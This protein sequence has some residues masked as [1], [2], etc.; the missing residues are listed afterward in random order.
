MVC[1][2]FHA[3]KTEPENSVDMNEQYQDMFEVDSMEVELS[4]SSRSV[5]AEPG[6]QVLHVEQ[7]PP[8]KTEPSKTGPSETASSQN[9]VAAVTGWYRNMVVD[10]ELDTTMEEDSPVEPTPAPPPPSKRGPKRGRRSA[11]FSCNLCPF[12][13]KKKAGMA[14]HLKKHKRAASLRQAAPSQTKER[15]E[16]ENDSTDG[17]MASKDVDASPSATATPEKTL[18]K[19]NG[20]H[21]S[22][23]ATPKKTLQK[24]NGQRPSAAATPE[25][26]LGKSNSQ[27]AAAIATP[28][29]TS[30]KSNNQRDSSES[31]RVVDFEPVKKL[32]HVRAMKKA[33]SD[34]D[35]DSLTSASD[36]SKS[37]HKD[38]GRKS[39]QP[40]PRS[41]KSRVSLAHFPAI[42]E[43]LQLRCHVC[44]F[45]T[46]YQ[47]TLF[48]HIKGHAGV[49]PTSHSKTEAPEEVVVDDCPNPASLETSSKNIGAAAPP[50]AALVAVPAASSEA[51]VPNCSFTEDGQVHLA[52]KVFIPKA[53]YEHLMGVQ[54]NSHF[55][56]R[57][58]TAIWSTEVLAQRSFTGTLSNRFVAEGGQKQ[59]QRPL[60]PHK[61]NALRVFFRHYASAKGLSEAET[62]EATKKIRMWLSQ[63]TSELRRARLATSKEQ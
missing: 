18:Q 45:T 30:E 32:H 1:C 47:A 42:K 8:V 37:L 55:V 60:S 57:S 23:T 56:K 40:A 35:T 29:K 27:R 61:V 26:I 6:P 10:S 13:T 50:P 38:K 62:G 16:S 12:V 39:P 14:L 41:Y 15:N 21:T 58:A 31:R 24:R 36:S 2:M 22:S 49:K 28:E 48:L 7:A 19:S 25:K 46:K 53:T 54:K 44:P 51:I 59:P 5:K 34:D 52:N 3:V 63:K 9:V 11:K 4:D 17:E 33:V 20:R 43:P